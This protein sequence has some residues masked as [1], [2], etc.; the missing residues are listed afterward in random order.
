MTY[1][2][3]PETVA[4]KIPFVTAAYV[5]NGQQVGGFPIGLYKIGFTNPDGDQGDT[6]K[7]RLIV[8]QQAGDYD[9]SMYYYRE[10]G[11]TE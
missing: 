5:E 6:S 11:A 7:P 8:A 3:Q 4:S 2:L 10:S 9:A 1:T